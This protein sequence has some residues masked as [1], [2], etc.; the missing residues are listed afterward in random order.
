MLSAHENDVK[1]TGTGSEI[2]E[3]VTVTLIVTFAAPTKCKRKRSE[4]RIGGLVGLPS[5]CGAINVDMLTV[6]RRGGFYFVLYLVC[7]KK[8]FGWGAAGDA[9][10]VSS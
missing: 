1:P 2:T 7:P 4:L 6:T 3:V 9:R 10:A 8:K 5:V